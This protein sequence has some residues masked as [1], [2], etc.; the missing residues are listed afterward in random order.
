LDL[1]TQSDK[2]G[3]FT[4]ETIPAGMYV[5]HIEEQHGEVP[6]DSTDLLIRVDARA[7]EHALSLVTMES[8]CG[9]SH[10]EPDSTR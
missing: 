3:A 2:D 8:G 6:F 10:L 5:L 1:Q 7:R 9:G 4:F